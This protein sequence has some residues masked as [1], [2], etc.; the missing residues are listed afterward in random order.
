[1]SAVPVQEAVLDVL[2]VSRQPS[3]I[4]T[5]LAKKDAANI[6]LAMTD[7]VNMLL[8]D[9]AGRRLWATQVRRP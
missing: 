5:V 6:A 1:M 4:S 8:V 3:Q 2:G 9:G 7:P